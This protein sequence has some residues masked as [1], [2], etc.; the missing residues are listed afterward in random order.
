MEYTIPQ[1]HLRSYRPPAETQFGQQ[2]RP[3]SNM[4]EYV[5]PMPYEPYQNPV[6]NYSP[7]EILK[8]L[9]EKQSMLESFLQP[10]QKPHAK[11][12]TLSQY[13]AHDQDRNFDHS[14]SAKL[15]DVTNLSRS[16]SA[17]S[18]KAVQIGIHV[19]RNHVAR[20]HLRVSFALLEEAKMISDEVGQ[21]CVFNTQI[22]NPA[23]NLKNTSIHGPGSRMNNKAQGNNIVFKEHHKFFVDLSRLIAKNRSK[24]D[25]FLMLQVLEKPEPDHMQFQHQTMSY[26]ASD[27]SNFGKLEYD[28]LGWLLF[29]VNKNDGRM[30]IGKFSKNLFSSPLKKPPFDFSNE[31]TMDAEIEFSI[32]EV[33]WDD[34]EQ[35]D[36]YDEVEE[37]KPAPRYVDKKPTKNYNQPINK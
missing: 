15:P 10:P 36:N 34:E 37:E 28:L 2:Q 3:V 5:Q 26:K 27:A 19:I 24:K 13:D 1:I 32:D 14:R 33:E 6:Q 21:M 18:K 30:H 9:A 8:T 7:Q 23:E 4:A 31:K 12:P 11:M 22:H 16:Q 20:N 17:Q 35:E 25:Y 29:K